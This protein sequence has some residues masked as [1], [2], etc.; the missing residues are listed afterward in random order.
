M[1]QSTMP[2]LNEPVAATP[3][4]PD[5]GLRPYQAEARARVNDLLSEHR[6][7]LV[8][9][10]TG[11]GKTRLAISLAWDR[12]VAG[13]KVL[14][15]APTIEITHQTY[16]AAR[17]LGL[18]VTIE[19]AGN[20]A[21]RPL[22]DMVVCC[23][24]TMRGSR[25]RSFRPDDFGLVVFDEAHASVSRRYTSISTY[26]R[27]AK[28]L[29]IT[30]TPDRADGRGLGAL[31]DVVA[32]EMH[33]MDGIEQGYLAP[34][35]FRTIHTDFNARKLRTVA[36]EVSAGSVA[37]EIIRSGLVHEAATALAEIAP[38]ERIVAF[39]PTVAASRAFV[40]EL[41]ARGVQAV[42]IDGTT[43]SP[44]RK[45][46]FARL[47]RLDIRVIANV[48]CLVE[49]FDL[50]EV[51]VV[52]LLN[53]SKSRARVAQMI[54]RGTRTAPGKTQCTVLDFCPGRLG[55][56]R[57]ASPADALAGQMLPDDVWE[58]LEDGNG[59]VAIEKAQAKAEEIEA[60]KLRAEEAAKAKADSVGRL[61][62]LARK[63]EFAY[64]VQ[65][66]DAGAILG[67]NRVDWGAYRR[68]KVTLEE[69]E[70]RRALGLCSPKQA[71]ILIR[72]GLNPDMPRQLASRAISILA[73]NK[74]MV[75]SEITRNRAFY[76]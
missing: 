48:G 52:A 64:E 14:F 31:Y 34:L 3:T 13:Q 58:H 71:R 24:A 55:K 62:G 43:P 44:T 10:A 32:H 63:R 51:S 18:T 72:A 36:G 37:A 25:L 56:G 65:E 50:P 41:L 19:Q 76:R 49:G 11:L 7:C 15:V 1:T 16:E 54:G 35:T 59:K 53:P 45:D 66:H 75:T 46:A 60:L 5:L 29:G 20:Y 69:A 21:S 57:L 26:F 47:K 27:H 23:V 8:V 38:S 61:Q 2:W 67:H 40:A 42:H 68:V 9:H 4:P 28:L 74:W 70:R 22:P 39:L 33:M 12:K 17:A 6:S 73:A 30:A